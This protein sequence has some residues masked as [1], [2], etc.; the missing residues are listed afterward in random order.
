VLCVGLGCVLRPSHGGC[1]NDGRPWCRRG[2][3]SMEDTKKKMKCSGNED[4]IK[5]S[6]RKWRFLVKMKSRS[7]AMVW[8]V[9]RG[10]EG[11]G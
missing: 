5:K 4:K 11:E 7:R 6:S 10:D 2:R 8:K 1:G 9:A 3:R